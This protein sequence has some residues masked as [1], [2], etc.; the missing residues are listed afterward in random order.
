M[1]EVSLR[2]SIVQI[3]TKD[4]DGA[5]VGFVLNEEGLVVTCAHVV[6]R[7]GVGPGDQIIV[8]FPDSSS[9]FEALVEDDGW[10]D[11]RGND[12]AFLQISKEIPEDVIPA[13][14]GVSSDSMSNSF[15]SFGF[16]VLKDEQG[17]VAFQG[18]W[19]NGTV[20]GRT[21]RG[22]GE[23]ALQ[24]T[25]YE[26]DQGYSGA[27]VLDLVSN[28]IIGIV[29]DVKAA[30]PYK[31]QQ[32][33]AWAT[34]AESIVVARPE[35][36]I[37]DS[38]DDYKKLPPRSAHILYKAQH[39]T[40][41]QS[42]LAVL[43][44]FWNRGKEGVLSLVGI[45]GAGKTAIVRRFLEQENWL[46]ASTLERP[47][48]LFIW[49][50]Y[51]APDTAEFLTEAYFY[52]SQIL[53]PDRLRVL[54]DGGRRANVFLLADILAQANRRFLIVMDGLEKMQSEGGQMSI[55]RGKIIDP[56]LRHL[57]LRI[58]DG[59]CGQT[60][61]IVTS[62]FPL[63]DL[64]EWADS[65]YREIDVDKL[66]PKAARSLLRR[67]GVKGS[68]HSLTLL[69]Q[70]Y[71]SH[72]LT[73]DLLGRLLVEYYEGD[74]LEAKYLP[75]VQLPQ[76][77]GSPGIV[78]QASKLTRVLSG[79]EAKLTEAELSILKC[80]SVFRR[81]ITFDFVQNVFLGENT[82]SIF[83][84]IAD[85]E[86]H[87]LR[88]LL[89]TL[90][91]RRL[92]IL[93]RQNG[94][95]WFTAH[96]AV[97]D[98]FYNS[99]AEPK[100]IHDTVRSH[101]VSLVNAPGYHKPL[102][103]RAI[104]EI[105]ELIYHTIKLGRTA[106]AYQLYKDRLGYL[107][108]GWN[109]GDHVRGA[110]IARLFG[111]DEAEP[112]EDLGDLGTYEQE[113][114]MIDYGLYLKNLG[115]VDR[116]IH[117]FEEVVRTEQELQIS[118]KNIAL[119]SQNLS[120]VQVLRGFLPGAEISARIALQAAKETSDI[121][122]VQ[123]CRVRLATALAFQGRIEEAELTFEEVIALLDEE[124]KEDFPRDL[125]GI[126]LGW[127]LMRIGRFDEAEAVLEETLRLA[128]YFN[129]GIICVR[130]NVLIAELAHR[131]NRASEAEE[132][133]DSVKE[134]A[135]KAYDQEMVV[136]LNLVSSQLA[137]Q[138]ADISRSQRSIEEGL[139][140]AKECGYSIYWIDLKVAEG[141]A[142]LFLNK[143]EDAKQCV[144]FALEGRSQTK[145][146][147]RQLGATQGECN[148][149]WGAGD[150]LHLLGEICSREG[151]PKEALDALIEAHSIRA[152]ISD[153]ELENTQRLISALR[154]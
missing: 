125:P 96:P 102:N 56:P 62:R 109:L 80:L 123:D 81:P 148:Y 126:R 29:T 41:R 21:T 145:G 140:V 108:L 26:L 53:S 52:F 15:A 150:A 27:P 152:R 88:S 68:D 122:L 1:S 3:R 94:E 85:M 47:D 66:E 90:A 6:Q 37:F 9:V 76:S 14:L 35:I 144:R 59:V 63:T 65:G 154:G 104:N 2:R 16:P 48:G 146:W 77:I 60:K 124:R 118:N 136:A 103:V 130:A 54:R 19:A 33:L 11:P 51:D 149:P 70:E 12:L 137:L 83:E 32:F 79:Y 95:Y 106:E 31:K 91:T 115:L 71:G 69:A 143:I 89:H 5:G 98:H 8:V 139:R 64:V 87:R 30:N 101:L 120:A 22:S 74:P 133:L 93:E 116:A 147:V 128:N 97:K 138:Q 10:C 13:Q 38:R 42:H 132:A 119:A 112:I 57:L 23:E 55:E 121:R 141:Y 43:K 36:P 75:Q 114:L 129:F 39:F 111:L 4:G 34:P 153:I 135:S 28:R 44:E 58:T 25:S 151:K 127:L 17:N 72:A 105:E 73:L 117:S 20:L 7:T 131:T 49:S 110:G 113:R 18:A 86:P 46:D 82:A 134:W 24:L 45:G 107:H 67:I 50:F 142:N 100:R 99:L 84:P 92:V 61:A 78:R 40:G